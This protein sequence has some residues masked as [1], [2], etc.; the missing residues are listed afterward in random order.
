MMTCSK[1]LFIDVFEC[2]ASAALD[3]IGPPADTEED[4]GGAAVSALGDIE[5]GET[6]FR[7]V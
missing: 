2:C 5:E 6:R 7:S 4:P 3:V 1:A